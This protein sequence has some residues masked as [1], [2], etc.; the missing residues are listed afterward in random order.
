MSDYETWVNLSLY[1]L[2]S[3]FEEKEKRKVHYGGQTK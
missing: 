2:C 1:K 3:L